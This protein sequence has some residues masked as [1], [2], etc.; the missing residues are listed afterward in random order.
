[1]TRIKTP[2]S[3][4]TTTSTY[5]EGSCFSLVNLRPMNGSLHP[6][7]PRKKM[8]ELSQK[9][10]IVFVHQNR[11]EYE[12]W[13]GV[14]DYIGDYSAVYWKIK[15]ETPEQ[16][17]YIDGKINSIEQIGNTLSVIT[18]DNIYYLLFQ[19]G[20]YIFLGELPQLPVIDFKTSDTMSKAKHYF[21]NEYGKGTV[22][23]DNFIDATK[24]LVN[25]AIDM[26]VN[27]GSDNEGNPIGGY[28]LQLFDAHFVRYAFRLYDGTLTK[29]SPPILV[30]PIRPIVGKE[31]EG[32]ADSIKTISYD[33]DDTLRTE[34]YVEV[35]GYRIA[36][37]YNF[38][39]LGRDNYERWT[40]IIKSV[41]IYMSQPLGLSSIENIREDM[42]TTDSPRALVYNLIKGMPPEALKNVENTSTFYLVRSV[43]LGAKINPLGDYDMLPS[44]ES[45]ISKME[46][47]V[48]QERMSDDQFSHHKQGAGVSYAYNNR[49][50]LANIK[51]TFFRGFNP[52]YFVWHNTV[53]KFPIKNEETGETEWV[54]NTQGNYNGFFYKDAPDTVYPTL[55]FEFDIAVGSTLE[56]V[57]SGYS[58]VY[59]GNEYRVFLSAFISYPDPR[60]QRVTLY[61]ID[62]DGKWYKL[63][64]SPMQKHNLLNIAFCVN[65]GLIPIISPTKPPIVS[66]PPTTGKIISL[67]ENK[68]KVSELNNPIVFPVENTYQ[69]GNGTVLAMATNAIRISEGQFG[70]FPLYIFTTQGIYSL[71][72]GSGEVVYSNISAPTSYEIPTTKIVASTPFG[73][74][75]TSAR[76]VCIIRGQEVEL[77]TQPLHEKPKELNVEFLPPMQ[78]KIH[79]YSKP[80]NEYLREIDSIIYDPYE[81]ELI[82]CDKES[83]FN[84]V[85][86]L[87]NPVQIAPFCQV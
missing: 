69:A 18:D 86:N 24:G 68:I 71:N 64:T 14:S 38:E 28:G 13:I 49:L 17:A 43:E 61:G 15:E 63:F 54:D 78:D 5:E 6:V 80:L 36:M 41:D 51:T 12:N 45:D 67:T 58:G 9:Y 33:F 70:Q 7:A 62:H 48:F 53:E 40:D 47:L 81:N 27:G 59:N 66:N 37:M 74:V 55:M 1:M 44:T 29:H 57:Y 85:L 50:H 52:K 77:L 79:N 30:M 19:N 2:L 21:A 23:P 8:Q 34:S 32:N 76:G 31:E 16:I 42:P 25:K 10:D 65:E 26:L 20:K 60:A 84:Y 3:G 11:G 4:I 56:R 75:F 87:E 46:N 35:F 83:K 82:I 72:V 22:K 73:V 39:Q